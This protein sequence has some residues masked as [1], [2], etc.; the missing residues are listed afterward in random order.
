MYLGAPFTFA[1]LRRFPHHRRRF[2]VAGLVITSAAL[3]SSSFATRVW[4]LI[5][6]QGVLYAT[7][8]STLYFPTIVFLDEWF[9]RRKGLA[10]G[11]MWA[12][13]GGKNNECFCSRAT[14]ITITVS[15]VCIPFV[16]N[17]GLSRYSF[18]TMLRA[19][20]IFLVLL[21]GPLLFFVK[22]RI[23]VSSKSRRRPISFTFLKTPTFWVLQTGNV[24]ESLGFFMPGLYLPS[25]VRALGLSSTA[26]TVTV[27]LLNTMSVFGQVIV[28]ALTDRLHVTTVILIATLGA[29]VWSSYSG[30]YL[31]LSHYCAFSAWYMA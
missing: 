21:A 31:P 17:W 29:T 3:V 1:L 20:S 19:W 8:G 6:T 5:L 22:P 30:D 7:G 4:H 23:P 12:G 26:G 27:S 9:I 2:S 25:Y 11:I 14:L 16:M 18:S 15:G 13:T 24:L 28:G 10:Y